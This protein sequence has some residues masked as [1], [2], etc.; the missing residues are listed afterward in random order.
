[1]LAFA[2]ELHIRPDW[3]VRMVR[4]PMRNVCFVMGTP[5]ITRAVRVLAGTVP[6]ECRFVRS[7]E[8]IQDYIATTK[9]R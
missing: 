4:P 6:D 7:Y 9:R 8:V 3:L 5:I 1:L 2:E